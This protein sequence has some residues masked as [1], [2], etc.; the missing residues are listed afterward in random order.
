MP[1]YDDRKNNDTNDTNDRIMKELKLS[2]VVTMGQFFKKAA[3][4]CDTEALLFSLLLHAV[5]THSRCASAVF[6]SLYQ[7]SG[8]KGIMYVQKIQ[9]QSL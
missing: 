1:F 9:S 2:D 6:V 4:S 8:N 3:D 5:L 7:F